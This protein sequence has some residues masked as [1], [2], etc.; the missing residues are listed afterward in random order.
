M[1][2]SGVQ[3]TAELWRGQKDS[4]FL[5]LEFVFAVCCSKGSGFAL[6]NTGKNG[7]WH[8]TL[9]SQAEVDEPQ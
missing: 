5:T 2:K 4:L 3:S 1:V 6:E 8:V 7:C 9:V